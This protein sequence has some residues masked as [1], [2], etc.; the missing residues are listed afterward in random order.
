MKLVK[1][2]LVRCN[3]KI[4]VMYKILENKEMF[5]CYNNEFDDVVRIKLDYQL[6][7]ENYIIENFVFLIII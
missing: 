2:F 1:F 6:V 3:I 5:M 7:V 4:G